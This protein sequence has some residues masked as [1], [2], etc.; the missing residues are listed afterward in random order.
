M[1]GQV[2]ILHAPNHAPSTSGATIR[3]ALRTKAHS[4]GMTEAYRVTR[5]LAAV[6][7]YRLTVGRGGRDQRRGAKDVPILTARSLVSYGAGAVQIS[8]AAKPARLA[9]DRWLTFSLF[10]SPA[11]PIAHLNL[12]P[13]A[14]IVG[15]DQAVPRVRE[16]AES[17]LSLER[18]ARLF[19]L[20]GF[21]PVVTGDLNYPQQ[22]HD[23]L[24]RYAP[25]E[26][27]Q[28]LDL[29]VWAQ[30]IDYI[31]HSPHLKRAGSGVLGSHETGSDHPW[32]LATFT[33]RRL[34]SA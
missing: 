34:Q 3:T 26:V 17:M 30:G 19:R 33:F 32:L 16:Y 5:L 14:A 7:D 20:E 28:R 2:T 4:I 8:E 21:M 10:E 13:N 29:T 15:R 9:P 27:F 18:Y 24:P 11:G 6:E 12:H 1:T 22:L 23:E 31:A 25:R